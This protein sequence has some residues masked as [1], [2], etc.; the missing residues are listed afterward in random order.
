M[1]RLV[2]PELAVDVI[3]Q[4]TLVQVNTTLHRTG[5]HPGI[6]PSFLSGYRIGGWRLQSM[7]AITGN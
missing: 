2:V 7:A 1:S 4:V 6:P 5:G 3:C